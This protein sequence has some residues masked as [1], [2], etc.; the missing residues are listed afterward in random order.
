[1]WKGDTWFIFVVEVVFLLQT[2]GLNKKCK[3]ITY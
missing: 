1:M 2:K 3:K